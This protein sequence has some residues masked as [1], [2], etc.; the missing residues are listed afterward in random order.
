MSEDFSS[1]I[2]DLYNSGLSL[3]GISLKLGCSPHKVVYWM[4]KLDIPRRKPSEALYLKYNP[5][6]DPFLIKKITTTEDAK[7][8]GLGVGI[9]WGEGD[10]RSI[11]ATRVANSDPELILTFI[12]FLTALCG[13]KKDKIKCNI[14]CFND[15][16]IPD[17][18]RYWSQL[19]QIPKEKFGKIVQIP[20][21]GKGK[22][23]RKSQYGVCTASVYNTKFKQWI[24]QEIS[25]FYSPR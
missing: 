12:H 6:G 1:T 3:G 22:Y 23:R 11:H 14:V 4:R 15:S 5:N 25:G 2:R 17:V 24:M 21:Q 16:N 8:F 9:Y 19:L 13:V 10:K 7:L 18:G 20:P